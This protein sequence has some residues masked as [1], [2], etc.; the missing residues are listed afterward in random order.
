MTLPLVSVEFFTRKLCAVI[1]DVLLAGIS[2][3]GWKMNNTRDFKYKPPR[4][5]AALSPEKRREI[6]ALGGASVPPQKRAFS[7]D[8]ELAHYAGAKGGSSVP[9]E[10]R[11]WKNRELAAAAGRK[12]GLAT[13]KAAEASTK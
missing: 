1:S 10:K 6:A 3:K 5:F 4:G 11:T 12:G 8:P 2:K 9:P 7:K 13:K